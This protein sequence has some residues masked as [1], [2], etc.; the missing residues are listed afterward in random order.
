[1]MTEQPPARQELLTAILERA[2]KE[3]ALSL[4]LARLTES[5]ATD[6]VCALLSELYGKIW[7][8]AVYDPATD[9]SQKFAA[10]LWPLIK[11]LNDI[12]GFKR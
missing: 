3:I 7:I 6:E 1:M 11:R 5:K 2:Q 9:G 8:E 4:E 12:V 10:A